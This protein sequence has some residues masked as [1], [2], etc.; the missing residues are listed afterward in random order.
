M[1]EEKKER[2]SRAEYDK[3]G[4]ALLELL[5]DCPHIPKGAKIKYNSKDVGTCVCIITTGGNY[6][7]KYISG[8]FAAELGLQIAYQSFPQGNGAIIDAQA[9]VDNI[10]KWFEDIDNLPKLK[11]GRRITGFSSGASFPNIEEVE[12]NTA[13]VFVV[14]ATMEYF[15]EKGE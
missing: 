5:G 9:V 7:Q 4:D 2:L 13:T 11:N 12:G 6:V 8:S 14:N 10:A 15:Y 3:I 1:L